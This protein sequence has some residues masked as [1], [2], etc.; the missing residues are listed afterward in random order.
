MNEI[1]FNTVYPDKDTFT[2]FHDISACVQG[3][4]E[5]IFIYI[6]IDPHLK[7]FLCLFFIK[8]SAVVFRYQNTL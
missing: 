3:Q 7:A 4:M 2:S 1:L 6:Y 5:V 8:L